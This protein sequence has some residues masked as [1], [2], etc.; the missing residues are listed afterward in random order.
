MSQLTIC[1]IIFALTVVG[2]CSGAYSLATVSLTSMMALTLTGCLEA[3]DAIAYF[4]N[5]NVIMI[6][7]MCVVAAGF[8]RTRFCTSIADGISRMANGSLNKMMLGYIVI[9]VLLSQFIQSP[10]VVFG[11]VAPM[12]MAS[13]ESMG[14]KPSK[15]MFPLG[16][17]TI[18][19]CCT[20]PVGAGATIAAELNGYLESY[21][22]MDF[23]VGITDP[24]KGRLPLLIIAVIYFAFFATK[25]APD[26]PVVETSYSA[27]KATVKAELKPYQEIAGIVIFFGDAL[28]LMFASTLGLANWEI[29][30]IG[31]LLMVLFGVLQPKEA[32]ASLPMSML[33]L[34]VGAL[35][36]SGALS[37]TGA[38]DAIGSRIA[39]L[40]SAVG[41]NSYI[42]GF[43]FFI[44][45]FL[46]TQVMQNRGTMLIFHP[47]AIATC[48]SIGGNPVGLM[49][50][51]QA[52]C[53]SA[54]MTPMATAA[55]PYIMDYGGYDQ[56]SMF[57]Q[58]GLIA[59]ICCVVSV[60]WIMTVFP[61]L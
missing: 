38:G 34:I 49:I 37:G 47:I 6:A 5:T 3:K 25:I 35:A 56:A 58:S 1:L 61:I 42:I 15:V 22:Y 44:I 20:L 40:V 55:V 27:K 45:P 53:L 33:L 60:G 14:I 29:T 41:G 17:A 31:A 21:G 26:A 43:I 46:L 24:M 12:L 52:A 16:A 19:T 11:I 32:T 59:V 48:A 23:M 7:G 9:G 57:K 13:A 51:I 10:V 36:M 8:N 54:F 28:A 50:L 30:V 39:V 2:Y 18:V 4:A